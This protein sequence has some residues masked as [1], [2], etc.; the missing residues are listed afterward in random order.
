MTP[1]L[2]DLLAHGQRT[3]S[4]CLEWQRARY[5]SGYGAV[6]D[7]K[8]TRRVHRVAWERLHGSVPDG[9]KVLHRCDNP[10]CFE[11]T[12]LFIGT[13]ADNVRDMWAKGRARPRRTK[14]TPEMLRQVEGLSSY[15]VERVLGIHHNTIWAARARARSAA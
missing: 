7:G 9:Q 14:V 1:T 10:P 13:Q 8:R 3:S 11:P 5:R 12:H 6:S 2:G 4:G 15:Q